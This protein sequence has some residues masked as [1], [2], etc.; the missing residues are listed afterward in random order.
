MAHERGWSV[1][2]AR[3]TILIG[4]AAMMPAGII[5]VRVESKLLALVLIGVVLFGFQSWINNVQTLPSDIFPQSSVAT[6]AG[7][8]GAGAGV[9]SMI[10]TLGTGWA[11]DHFSFT[12][13][14]TAA[15]LLGPIGLGVILLL[16][17]KIGPIVIEA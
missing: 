16:I 15:G 11:V 2:H 6:V 4:S 10:F 5:A 1:D 3:K 9:G 8:A 13:V 12:P 14:L 17:G 7:L